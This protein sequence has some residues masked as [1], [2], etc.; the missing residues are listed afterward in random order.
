MNAS[1][2]NLAKFIVFDTGPIIT[3]T[4]TNLLWLVETL[5]KQFNGEFLIPQ[6]VKYELIDK[7]LITKRFKFEA[8]YVL[9]FIRKGIIKINS[10][11]VVVKTNTL[12]DTANRIYIANHIPM[13]IVQRAEMETLALASALHAKA[14]V[15]DER[16]TRLLI[17]NPRRLAKL[18]AKKLHTKILINMKALREFQH[19][20]G[21]I[22]IIRSVDLLIYAF[23]QN[24][25]SKFIPD[26]DK[27]ELLDALLWAAKTHGC[28]ISVDEIFDVMRIEGF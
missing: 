22:S 25:L 16:T 7:P 17:E 15:I 4:T 5:K 24:L 23:E 28:S 3:L 13:H 8:L 9:D 14:V 10:T 20:V 27:K 19:Q 11:D 12:M 18:F 6:S 1:M 2:T 21:K 26:S